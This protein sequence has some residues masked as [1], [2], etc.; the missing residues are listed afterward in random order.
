MPSSVPRAPKS[1]TGVPRPSRAGTNQTSPV[2]A[3]G[4]ATVVG[5]GGVGDEA[6]VVAQPLDA[7]AG[8]Q[9]DRLDA[10]GVCAGRA[11]RRRSGR[12]PAAAALGRRPGARARCTGRA[13]RRCRRSPWPARAG[14]ALPDERGLLVAGDPADRRAPRAGRAASPTTPDESTTVGSTPR[15]MRS[16]SSTRVVPAGAVARHAGPV[17]PALV[18]SVTCSGPAATG[19]RRPS[20]STVPKQRSRLAT[21]GSARS[22]RHGQ[23]GGRHVGR[24]ADALLAWRA[25]HVPTVR[26]SC[27]PMP[28]PTGSPV[29][30]SQTIVEA[31]WLAIPT[32]V[33]RAAR[34]RAPAVATLEHGRGHGGGVELDEAR[35]RGGAAAPSTVVDVADGAVGPRRWRPARPIVPTS[36]T[37][38][39]TSARGRSRLRSRPGDR[40]E[41]GG[42]AELARVEDPPRVEG[43]LERLRARRS[44]SPS[45]SAMNRPG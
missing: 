44:P 42:Q 19:S 17:T 10:P 28:G 43:V 29:A 8:R 11:A 37:R 26:R 39:L 20:V 33:D 23:L 38:T 3:H 40:A 7:R 5:L 2:S 32:A 1:Q 36:T 21:S 31:R 12:C 16:A 18:A 27:Q 14:A 25:R 4:A 35:G 15:G 9:H 22:R 34:R 30:R 13:S 6:E 24:D 41:G 45:A